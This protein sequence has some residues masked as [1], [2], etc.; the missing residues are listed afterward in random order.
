MTGYLGM[1]RPA[2]QSV[3]AFVQHSRTGTQTVQATRKKMPHANFIN[4]ILFEIIDST[5]QSHRQLSVLYAIT[6]VF[7]AISIIV[8]KM[9]RVI[10]GTYGHHKLQQPY[11]WFYEYCQD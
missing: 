2:Q 9:K 3:V 4:D 8:E 6:N 7:L 10:I 1:G 5:W 11:C